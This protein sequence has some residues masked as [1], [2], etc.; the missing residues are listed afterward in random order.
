MRTGLTR[1]QDGCIKAVYRD[2]ATGERFT[3]R[4]RRP[5]WAEPD[6]CTW[7]LPCAD[8]PRE[9]ENWC[10]KC[11]QRH[12]YLRLNVAITCDCGYIIDRTE[13]LAQRDIWNR[14]I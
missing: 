1:I 2:P 11:K 12:R 5:K 14:R 6:E 3:Q 4:K 13:Q 10:P 7:V 9:F 8:H